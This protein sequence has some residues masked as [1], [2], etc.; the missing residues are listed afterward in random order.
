MKSQNIQYLPAVDHLRGFA[1]I[2]IFVY[3][4]YI[5]LGHQIEFGAPFMFTRWP[6]ADNIV[7]ALVIEG[8][9]AVSL[10]MVLSGFIFT[11]GAYQATLSYVDFLR[12]RLLRTYPLFVLLLLAGV[13]AYPERFSLPALAQ[14][15]FFLA[16]LRG[17]FDA[18]A[19]SAMFWTIAVEWQF[20]LVFPLLILFVNRFGLRYVLGLLLV[21]IVL[22][23]GAV[24]L[25]ANARDLSYWTILGRMDQ[26]LIGIASGVLFRRHF[27]AGTGMDVLC[28]ASGG[29]VLML[30]YAFNQAGG[31]LVVKPFK[32]L[33]PTVEALA[34]AG[35]ILGY[36]SLSRW[37]PALLSRG[38]VALGTISYSM[39][40]THFVIIDI[41][42][43]HRL[44]LHLT[45]YAPGTSALVSGL[46]I[47]LPV[48]LLVST[49]TYHTVEKPFLALRTSYVKPDAKHN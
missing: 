44:F 23:L 47:I 11:I 41:C 37:L 15:I 30:L 4:V 5:L 42:I 40:L 24:A 19:I 12:N 36:L 13:C 43:R 48:V 32:V 27:R 8:H 16:N 1:A 28:I 45:G 17:A 31:S 18:G 2:L 25:G 6:D 38:L 46:L 3:H 14:S 35:V 7:A 34:W 26:F 9:T 21:F 33:W 10:F 20:Y 49:L 39:Y 29:A 22:R